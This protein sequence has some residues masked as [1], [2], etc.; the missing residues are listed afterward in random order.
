MNTNDI[1]MTSVLA[2]VAENRRREA[3]ARLV[4]FTTVLVSTFVLTAVLRH[5]M[6]IWLAWP[7]ASLIAGAAGFFASHYVRTKRRSA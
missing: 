7:I 3:T 6:P 4:G 1:D 5:A 2:W